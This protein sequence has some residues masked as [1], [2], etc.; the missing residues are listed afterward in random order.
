MTLLSLLIF[1]APC[2][3][4][5]NGTGPE[6]GDYDTATARVDYNDA[7]RAVFFDFS[8]GEITEL[9]HDF[10]DI[11]IN[12][13]GNIIANSGSY[14]SGV[15]VYKTT[16]TDISGNFSASESLV[17]EY[18][19]REGV[20][21]YDYQQTEANPIEDL[22]MAPSK[23]YLIKVQYGSA[24]EEYFKVQFAMKM[25]GAGGYAGPPAYV[26]TAVPG[27]G[28]GETGKIELSPSITGLTAGYGWLY[29]KL[30][31]E[32]GPRVL[33]N[34]TTW[35][36]DGTAVPQAA[37]WDL[38]FT[39]TIELQTEDGTTVSAGM[40]VASRSSVLLN[41]YKE[42][43]AAAVDLSMEQ[44]VDSE[45]LNFSDDV[46]AIGY[47]WYEMAGM[48]PTFTVADKTFVV[49]TAEEHYAKFQPGTFYGPASESFYMTFRYFYSGNDTGVFDK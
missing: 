40:P 10:F 34:G 44:V 2:M 36:A 20:N 12:A 11:A 15:Q 16:S 14:G 35:T 29:F 7:N 43:E 9:D 4:C 27:L 39:R 8:T 38:L 19:F 32:D 48:P 41:T 47:G 33:N 21:L 37:D 31:G 45:G 46:D 25:P 3:S 42:V 49:K 18:T 24:A 6:G 26:V 17:K 5:D 28:A 22:G 30:V 1:T 23:V 13:G